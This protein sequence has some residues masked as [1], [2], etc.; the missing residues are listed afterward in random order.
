MLS[1]R[2]LRIYFMSLPIL[3]LKN[4]LLSEIQYLRDFKFIS[5]I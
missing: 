1:N 4:Q 2:L 5:S 3:L